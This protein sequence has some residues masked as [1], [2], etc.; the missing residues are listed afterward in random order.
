M[1]DVRKLR[2]FTPL[3]D[4]VGLFRGHS[5]NLTGAGRG[6]S[7]PAKNP[8]AAGI[9]ARAQTSRRQTEA[10]FESADMKQQRE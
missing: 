8:V 4:T 10:E 5:V 2:Q 1:I 3:S 7:H 6:D 9:A